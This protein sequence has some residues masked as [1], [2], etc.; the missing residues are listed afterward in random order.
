MIENLINSIRGHAENVGM[1]K[2]RLSDAHRLGDWDTYTEAQDNII[3]CN[4]IIDN[5][6]AQLREEIAELVE[7]YTVLAFVKEHAPDC[8]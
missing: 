4:K 6:I 1:Y 8:P 7:S 2:T 5:R 3:R